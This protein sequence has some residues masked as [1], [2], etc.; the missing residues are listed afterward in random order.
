MLRQPR[1]MNVNSP[2]SATSETRDL[3]LDLLDAAMRIITESRN[4]SFSLRQLA[5]AAGT[6]TMSIYTH[7]GN[8]EGLH[9]ALSARAFDLFA[10]ALR[11]ATNKVAE[12]DLL[13]QLRAMAAAYRSFALDHPPAFDLLFG[14]IGSLGAEPALTNAHEGLP[15]PS[16]SGNAVYGMYNSVFEAGEKQG[17][18]PDDAP[19]QLLMDSFWAQ[20]HGLV[21]LE[22][23]GY[24]RSPDDAADRF[25]Y[26]VE[27]ILRGLTADARPA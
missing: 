1:R 3:R 16:E 14:D 20:M 24:I 9:R 10:E 25:D 2:L 15:S 19:V 22:R 18:F 6:S 12:D 13:Y 23:L 21:A 8:R 11:Q 7:F 4:L 26:G 17:L 5:D 27:A